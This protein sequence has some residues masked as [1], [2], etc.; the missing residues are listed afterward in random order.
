MGTTRIPA[1]L[2]EGSADE[3]VA[4]RNVIRQVWF[5]DEYLGRYADH[6]VQEIDEFLE[7]RP[8]DGDEVGR[9]QGLLKWLTHHNAVR[10]DKQAAKTD[11]P[12]HS[13]AGKGAAETA[14]GPRPTMFEEV[15]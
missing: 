3:H 4:F 1:L 9:L 15:P 13:R 2:K 6:L 5:A 10:A 7:R 14:G 11:N 12:S 8:A